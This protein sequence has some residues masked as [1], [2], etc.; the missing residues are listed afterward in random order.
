MKGS[1]N[2]TATKLRGRVLFVRLKGHGFGDQKIIKRLDDLGFTVEAVESDKAVNMPDD[3]DVRLILISSTA[4]TVV[5]E[6]R[7]AES[8]VPVVVLDVDLFRFMS[9]SD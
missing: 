7:F 8:P 5:L 1:E 9:L 3:K 4:E 6:D 2:M